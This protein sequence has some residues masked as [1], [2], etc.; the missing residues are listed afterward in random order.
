MNELY[1]EAGAKRKPNAKTTFLKALCICVTIVLLL[2]GILYANGIVLFLGVAAIVALVYL[3]PMFNV[4]YEYIFCDGQF[5]FDKIMGGNKRKNIMKLDFDSSEVLAP[6]NSHALDSYNYQ[7]I[8]VHD[9]TSGDKDAKVYA[10]VGKPI[11]KKDGTNLV[12]VLF[13]PDEK[14]IAYAKQKSPRKVMEY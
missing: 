9:F 10:L 4:D 6:V 2:G 1:A 8:Q 14:M 13:E 7:K 3:F 11:G 5:D 12:K